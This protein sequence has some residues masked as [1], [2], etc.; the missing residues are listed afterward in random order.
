MAKKWI[1]GNAKKLVGKR[2]VWEMELSELLKIAD[3]LFPTSDKVRTTCYNYDL[4][5]F[6][7]GWRFNVTNSWHKWSA[8]KLDHQFGAYE[9]PEFAIAAFLAYVIKNKIEPHK[10]Y[11]S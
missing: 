4:A 9:K 3:S 1:P 7:Y 8:K 10:L 2:N 11:E 6:P 5:R